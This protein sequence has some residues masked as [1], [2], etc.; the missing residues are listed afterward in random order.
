[1]PQQHCNRH[2]QQLQRKV[3]SIMAL[4]I[5]IQDILAGIFLLPLSI[6]VQNRLSLG[7]I[8]Q[9]QNKKEMDCVH[10]QIRRL[11]SKLV[12]CYNKSKIYFI[13]SLRKR[14]ML[15]LI[16]PPQHMLSTFKNNYTCIATAH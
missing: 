7:A 3:S 12:Q 2:Q 8:E 1:M 13:L 14:P 9:A 11:F 6:N 15:A 4:T 10:R 5:S 16:V